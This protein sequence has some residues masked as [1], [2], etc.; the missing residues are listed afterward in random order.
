MKR[1][2]ITAEELF[3]LA[4]S[5]AGDMYTLGDLDEEEFYLVVHTVK[6][7]NQRLA[8]SKVT[9]RKDL[10]HFREPVT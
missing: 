9:Y 4:Q 1:G 2:K 6:V 5:T 3:K 7:L 10:D 8:N